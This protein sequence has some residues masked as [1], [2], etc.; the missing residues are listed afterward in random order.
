MFCHYCGIKACAESVFCS[1]CGKKLT[2]ESKPNQSEID[3]SH[4]ARSNG[5]S[6]KAPKTF[7]EFFKNAK[8]GKKISNKG[9]FNNNTEVTIHVSMAR[10]INDDTFRQVAGS[11]TPVSLDASSTYDEVK[12][13]AFDKL[14][15]YV[16]EMEPFNNWDIDLCFR[17][18]E[19]AIFLPG[20]TVEFTLD[21]YKNDLGVKYSQVLLYLK[22]HDK[23]D[24][25]SDDSST[26]SDSLP[27]PFDRYIIYLIKCFVLF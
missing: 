23:P 21:G 9:S 17:S 10:K 5:Q 2:K 25:P 24:I 12:R 7:R 16:P 4:A 6:S 26:D 15:R 13:K 8:K 22:P 27:N 20:T 14:K 3:S 1:S 18:G 11:R 19:V